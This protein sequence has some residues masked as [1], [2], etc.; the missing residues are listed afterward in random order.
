MKPIHASASDDD[1][2]AFRRHLDDSGI[3]LI[4]TVV[5]GPANTVGRTVYVSITTDDLCRLARR[6]GDG[7]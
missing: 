4:G 2:L 7:D 3:D 6:F 5:D 1:G